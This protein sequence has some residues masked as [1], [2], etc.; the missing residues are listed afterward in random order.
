MKLSNKFYQ[1]YV[2]GQCEKKLIRTLIDQQLIVPGKADVLNPVQEYIRSAHL[3][4]LKNKTNI[5]LIFDTDKPGNEIM[6]TNLDFL[7]SRPNIQ[8]VITVPQV[9]NLEEELIRCTDIR[10]IRDLLNC[11]HDSD[12]KTAFIE[13]KRLFDKLISH[14]F[15]LER[16][17][18]FPPDD[19]FLALHIQN[20]GNEIKL[21][22]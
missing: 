19:S 4:P 9:R 17:W 3:R 20:Q 8:R 2:E 11:K 15:D 6:K 22:R 14:K 13:E 21:L 5:I 12:F 10:H 16:L 1:Y 18:S 7:K